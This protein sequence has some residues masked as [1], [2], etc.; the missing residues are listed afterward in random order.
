VEFSL[1]GSEIQE[2]QQEKTVFWCGQSS[3]NPA[4]EYKV[5][6]DEAL[7]MNTNSLQN[8]PFKET[9]ERV[10]TILLKHLKQIKVIE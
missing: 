7:L 4:K 2:L 5:I 8:I 6:A 3:L 9:G 10:D 1:T